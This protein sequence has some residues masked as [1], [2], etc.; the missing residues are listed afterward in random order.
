MSDTFPK[1]VRVKEILSSRY[2]PGQRP[3][4][5]NERRP[6]I[7]IVKTEQ[8]E[9]LELFSNGGQSTPN[10]GWEILLTGAAAALP[11]DGEKEKSQNNEIKGIA[12]T[13]YGIPSTVKVTP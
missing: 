9:T 6:G 2:E 7:E 8:G 11:E 3:L 13:L 12:W 4:R 1:R 10:V 5:W